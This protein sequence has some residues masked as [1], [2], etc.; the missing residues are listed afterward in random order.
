MKPKNSTPAS[1]VHEAVVA[2]T[3]ITLILSG[4]ATALILGALVVIG[5]VELWVPT[6]INV[7]LDTFVPILLTTAVIAGVSLVTALCLPS[8]D[9]HR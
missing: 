6:L 9:K 5:L 4:G 3:I 2:T 7:H 1:K 8:L